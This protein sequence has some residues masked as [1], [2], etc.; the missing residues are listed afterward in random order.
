MSPTPR[1]RAG[2]DARQARAERILDVTAELLLAHGYRKV[3]VDDVA[4]HAGIGKGTIYLHWRTREALL[5]AVLQR[6]TTRLLGV[7]V[8]RLSDDAEL[9]LP[10]R[11]MS[12]IF[13]EVA[14]RP[15]VK[16]LLL[17]DP[18]V[19][20]ALAA[21]EAVAAAQR[22]LAGNENYFELVRAQGLLRSDVGVEQA[23]YLLESVIRGFFASADGPDVERSAE[24][25]AYVLRRT[26]EPDEPA[27]ATAVRALNAAVADLFRAL[28]ATLRPEVAGTP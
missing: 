9:A 19:L 14:H 17:A 20:G 2:S 18:E 11:L 26:V 6:E 1:L 8:D 24:L 7:L 16:A 28:A 12:A 22:E 21:D 15:L 10:H 23:G 27:P 5:W 4:R 25:L 13:L 3:T